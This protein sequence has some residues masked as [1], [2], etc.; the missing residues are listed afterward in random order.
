PIAHAQHSHFSSG[1][2]APVP[3]AKLIAVNSNDFVHAS[4]YVR[5]LPFSTSG[6]YA[7]FYNASCPFIVA[8][9]T[10]AFGGPEAGA[11]A[12]GSFIEMEFISLTGPAGGVLGYWE[13]SRTG[14][15]NFALSSGVTNG[16]NR[17]A[18][19]DAALGA[20]QP[21]ADPFGH[22]HGRRFTA[23]VFGFY[24][25]GYRFR[26]TSTNGL[27]HGPIHAPSQ[28]YYLYLQAG[29]TVPFVENKKE[30]LAIT[31]GTALGM[32]FLLQ[33]SENVGAL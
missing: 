30:G 12:L 15:P 8:A 3:G 27:N 11:P 7:N 28:T 18:L 2:E 10:P 32:N 31:Y 24:T 17:I 25:L 9:A 21:G 5:T 20:G 13:A 16:T 22:I 6:T 26:D 19:S 14:A 29:L 4:G 1:A 33:F 23:N